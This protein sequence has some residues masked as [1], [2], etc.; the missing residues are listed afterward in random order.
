MSCEGR[1][2]DQGDAARDQEMHNFPENQQKQ[3]EKHRQTSPLEYPQ[4]E[5]TLLPP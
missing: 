2:R 4:R 3:T 1:G 5:P